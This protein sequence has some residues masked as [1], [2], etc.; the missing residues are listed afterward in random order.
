MRA[1]ARGVHV[2]VHGVCGRVFVC[3][4]CVFANASVRVCGVCR[5]GGWEGG[6][7]QWLKCSGFRVLGLV[8]V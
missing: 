1:C 4:V 6:H 8:R 2:C 5:G 7:A 3:V